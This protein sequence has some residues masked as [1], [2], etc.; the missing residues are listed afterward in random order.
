M[1]PDNRRTAPLRRSLLPLLLC[2]TLFP[3]G[4]AKTNIVAAASPSPSLPSPS[5][6]APVVVG[7]GVWFWQ[8]SGNMNGSLTIVGNGA[9][10]DQMIA[11]LKDMEYH[12]DL[13]QLQR[14][15]RFEPSDR[16]SVESKTHD[17]WNCVISRF[18]RYDFFSS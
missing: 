6:P 5:L 11:N 14:S 12:N 16:A 18:V 4:C 7:R 15:D 2:S 3:I 17:E 10:E 9:L 13:R 8:L 1:C